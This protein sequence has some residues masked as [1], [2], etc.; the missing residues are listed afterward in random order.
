MPVFTIA[1][2]SRN[3]I[4]EQTLDSAAEI[5]RLLGQSRAR[6][7]RLGITGALLFNEGRFVQ[8]LEGDEAPVL[9]VLEDIKRDSRHAD[10]DV[11]PPRIVPQRSF[12]QWSMAFIGSSPGARDYYRDSA[13]GSKLEWT[14]TTTELLAALMLELIM[15]DGAGVPKVGGTA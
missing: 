12:A 1:Y 13:F 3:L 6:N 4:E 14:K 2:R 11:L 8:I 10:V 7:L 9:E 15:I 5:Q